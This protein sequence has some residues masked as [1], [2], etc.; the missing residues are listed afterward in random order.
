MSPIQVGS[1]S[2]NAETWNR[3]VQSGNIVYGYIPASVT[4]NAGPAQ[5]VVTGPESKE[6]KSLFGTHIRKAVRALRG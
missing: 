4:V 5:S 6:D 3:F 1:Q 2:Q